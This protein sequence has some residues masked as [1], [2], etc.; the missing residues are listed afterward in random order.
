MQRF[1]RL[2][3]GRAAILLAALV[4]ST[5]LVEADSDPKIVTGVF[6]DT[7]Q[8]VEGFAEAHLGAQ[9]SVREATRAIN[10]AAGKDDAC[11]PISNAIVGN[12]EEVKDLKIAGK[13]YADS[14]A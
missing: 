7:Q 8:Q 5:T 11:S 9:L 3:G 1:T 6:C 10:K 14:S 13:R 12:M 2:F 4:S